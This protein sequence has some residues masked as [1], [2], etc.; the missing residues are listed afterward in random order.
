MKQQ[1]VYRV[2][3]AASY[4]RICRAKL[5][6]LV[7]AGDL[8][9]RKIGAVTILLDEDVQAYKAALEKRSGRVGYPNDYPNARRGLGATRRD[10]HRTRGQILEGEQGLE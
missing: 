9:I 2:P 3:E 8:S 6:K 5:Y 10:G 4:L 7:A 1:P